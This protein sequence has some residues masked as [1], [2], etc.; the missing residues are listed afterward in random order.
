MIANQYKRHINMGF[1][2][3]DAASVA[4]SSTLKASK[5]SPKKIVF[6]RVSPFY[7]DL[8]GCVH[9]HIH[10]Q[11]ANS[12]YVGRLR[13]LIY[14]CSRQLRFVSEKGLLRMQNFP[15]IFKILYPSFTTNLFSLPSRTVLLFFY[16]PILIRLGRRKRLIPIRTLFNNI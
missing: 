12:V 6:Y 15:F 13:L 7:S 3:L 16:S 5:I 1:P 8:F 9:K 2:H 10:I 4:A 14:I 11:A